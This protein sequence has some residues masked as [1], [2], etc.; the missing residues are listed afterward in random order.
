MFVRSK[1]KLDLSFAFVALCISTAALVPLVGGNAATDPVGN[2]TLQKVWAIVYAVFV[3]LVVRNL[4]GFRD[5]LLRYRAMLFITELA[6]VSTAWSADPSVT[7]RRSVALGFTCLIAIY[8][9][10][11]FDAQE[12]GGLVACVLAAVVLASLLFVVVDPAVGLDPTHPGSWRGVFTTKNELG[13][14]ASL[15]TLIWL[16]RTRVS[17]WSRVSGLMMACVSAWVTWESGSKTSLVVVAVI[18]VLFLALPILRARPYLVIAGLAFAFAGATLALGI[19]FAHGGL[20]SSTGP[21]GTLTGRTAIWA[22]VWRAIAA[23][24]LL[25]YGYGA[26]WLGWTGPSAG[27]WNQLGST[28]PHAHNGILEVWLELGAIGVAALVWWLALSIQSAWRL[29]RSADSF[30]AWPLLFLV[31]TVVNNLT[32]VT[33]VERNSFV[34]LVALAGAGTATR[35]SR[36]FRI[37]SSPSYQAIQAT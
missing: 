2:P 22:A 28:P 34:W 30:S 29:L 15:S 12:L 9:A 27:V 3:I 25:G 33:F 36:E 1:S 19:V 8:L 17:G 32:E 35:A 6:L 37:S 24:P 21:Y 7:V 10:E 14:L 11:R 18:F 26:F 4:R 16:L 31:A 23:H 20:V 5:L 13:R